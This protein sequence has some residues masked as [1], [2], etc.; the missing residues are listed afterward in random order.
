MKH[1]IVKLHPALAEAANHIVAAV[2]EMSAAAPPSTQPTTSTGYSYSLDALSDED[3]SSEVN[4]MAHNASLKGISWTFFTGKT[5]AVEVW[6]E[7]FCSLEGKK[8][9]YKVYSTIDIVIPGLLR[10]KPY[11]LSQTAR[12]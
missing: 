11:V 7:D 4:F 10:G 3:D 2:H 5:K 6:W 8:T 9:K 12:G 1:R